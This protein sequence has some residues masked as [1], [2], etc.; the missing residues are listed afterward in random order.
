MGAGGYEGDFKFVKSSIKIFT[1]NSYTESILQFS[2]TSNRPP[3]IYLLHKIFNPYFSNVELFRKV[4]FTISLSIPILFF[5]CLKEKFGKIE[6]EVL[7]LF[8]SL[9]F[10]NPF[11]RTSSY[12][13]LEE[14]YAI[15]TAL[16]SL[17]FYLKISNSSNVEKKLFT[18]NLILLTFFSSLTIYFDQKFLIIPII[19]FL[20]IFFGNYPIRYK[21]INIFLYSLFAIPYLF[22]IKLWGGIFPSDIYH[23]GK[24]FHFHHLGFAMSM[25]AFIFFPFL[26]LKNENIL[27]K[28]KSFTTKPQN[29]FI[30]LIV[31]LYVLT[32]IFFYEDSFLNDRKDGGGILKKLSFIFFQELINK[33]IFIFIGFIISWIFIIFFNENRLL[34]YLLTLYFLIISLLIKPFYQEYFDPII[35][36]LLFFVFHLDLKLNFKRAYILYGY[37]LIFLVGTHFYYN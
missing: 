1:E 4:V 13:G 35:F 27:E 3:L 8:T 34:N 18:L 28:I 33:K 26:F 9:I 15:I 36:L 17:F 23:L 37:Y 20:K 7:L 14:N 21:I 32:L 12:W 2:S 16:A 31:I 11:Y 22:L 5:F 29:Y 25:I 24:E 19:C 6:N 30:F 10:F